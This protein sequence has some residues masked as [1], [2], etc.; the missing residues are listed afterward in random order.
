M[1]SELALN[2][3]TA[4]SSSVSSVGSWF[5]ILLTVVLCSF[6]I[7]FTIMIISSFERY[8]R[9]WKLLRALKKSLG[10]FGWGVLSLITLA[11]PSGLIYWEI[12][13]ASNGNIVPIKW[14]VLPVTLYVLISVI[15]FL[16]KKYIVDR[17]KKYNDI[18]KYKK[19]MKGIIRR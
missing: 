4:I 19:K 15:G 3:T 16:V 2:A 8:E 10:F 13:Q 12:H 1:P 18:I 9:F 17:I 6:M 7:V 14:T 11:V 5:G